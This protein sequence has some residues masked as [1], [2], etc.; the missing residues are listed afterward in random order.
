[1]TQRQLAVSAGALIACAVGL[2]VL[3]NGIRSSFGL[4]LAPVTAAHAW[5]GSGFAFAIAVQI[6]LNGATQPLWGQ[7]AD[8]LGG[9]PVLI[10]GA[11]LYAIGI[12]GMALAE[13]LGVFTF[14][15][16]VV[17]GLAVSAAGTP[18]I[19]AAL[20]RLLPPEMR[21]RAVGLSTAGSSAGQ[22]LVVPA[23]SLAIGL[24]GWQGALLALAAAALLIIPLALPVSD[25]PQ[26]RPAGA[27]QEETA[28]AAL[29]RA[30]RD[31]SFWFLFS[32]FFVCGLH[33]SFMG[34]HMPGF[35]HSCGLPDYVG[36]ASISLIGLF[37]IAGSLVAGEL[38]SRWRRKELLVMIYASRGV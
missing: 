15:A 25:R 37:N 4:F 21:G 23:A 32:G 29:S 6:L 10:I 19:S 34:V 22:F 20:T 24:W 31:P 14:F 13:N 26:P 11:A 30:F 27:P 7:V 3:A 17:L 2:A 28:R 33:V 9:R 8:R 5:T 35:V 12:L 38:S 16:G 36:A 1:M 18:T